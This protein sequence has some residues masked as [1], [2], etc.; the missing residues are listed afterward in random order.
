[1]EIRKFEKK[2]AK[3]VSQIIKNCY[4]NLNIG[5][6]TQKGIELQIEGNSP[7]NLIKRSKNIKYYIALENNKIIGICGYDNKKVYTFF[8][9]TNYHNKGI[10]KE[11]LTKILKEAKSEG[12]KSIKTWST[13]YAE[14]FYISFGFI[15]NK[16]IYLPEGEKDIILIE[17]E[18][19]L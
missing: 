16:E 10:G 3:I 13:F 4:L 8:I 19:I 7:K 14:K 5:G 11:L 17:M 1:M 15:T 12:I 6:H 9:D 2:D 18:K